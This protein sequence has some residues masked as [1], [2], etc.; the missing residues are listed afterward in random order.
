MLE[1]Y[2][3]DYYLW[4]YLPSVLAAVIFLLVFLACTLALSW[5]SWKARVKFSI[6]FIIG[7]FCK[8]W[9]P[10]VRGYDG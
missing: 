9:L 10:E 8:C 2:K 3:G 7:T 6:P 5:R 4:H 1:P